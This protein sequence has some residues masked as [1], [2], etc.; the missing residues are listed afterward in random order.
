MPKEV[1]GRKVYQRDDLIDPN[2]I[3]DLG[4][5]NLERMQKGSAPVGADGKEIN[6][7][8]LMQDEPGSM[9]EVG[10]FFIL[11]VIESFNFIQTNG[12][13]HG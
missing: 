10:A 11:H 6:L 1:E 5:S 8:H 13:N 7:H 12:I 3:D 4:K 2:R 9:A